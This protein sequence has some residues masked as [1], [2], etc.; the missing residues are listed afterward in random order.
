MQSEQQRALRNT[1]PDAW[2]A[3]CGAAPARPQSASHAQLDLPAARPGR[4]ARVRRTG[5]V[6]PAP[7]RPRRAF[8]KNSDAYVLLWLASCVQG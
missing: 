6:G 3:P 1:I 2:S 8:G 4:R 7:W 5:A